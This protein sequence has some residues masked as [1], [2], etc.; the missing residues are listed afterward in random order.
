MI[1]GRSRLMAERH[2][3]FFLNVV[4]WWGNCEVVM[5]HAQHLKKKGKWGWESLEWWYRGQV[6]ERDVYG[7]KPNEKY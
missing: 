3:Y 5:F 7:R 1:E 6:G 4:E 2:H